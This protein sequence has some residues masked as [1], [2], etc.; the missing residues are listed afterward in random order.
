MWTQILFGCLAAIAL[1][2]WLM[3]EFDLRDT[4]RLLD[5]AEHDR[6]LAIGW[7]ETQLVEDAVV[8]PTLHAIKGGGEA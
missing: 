1:T 5:E 6:D 2:G 4:T 7:A 8:H 3:S